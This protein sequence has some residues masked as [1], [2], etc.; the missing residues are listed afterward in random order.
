MLWAKLLFPKN[1]Y[2]AT[3]TLSI[4]QCNYMRKRVAQSNTRGAR[5]HPEERSL[6]KPR[7]RPQEKPTLLTGLTWTP[8]LQNYEK[9]NFCCLSHPACGIFYGSLRKLIQV[10]SWKPNLTNEK[11]I[12]KP[13]E[14]R[15]HFWWGSWFSN[16]DMYQNHLQNLAKSRY[17]GPMLFPQSLSHSILYFW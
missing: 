16:F 12:G 7:K 10:G 3:L 1:S 8:V 13:L 5:T 2:V 17:S 4:S 11:N 14:D 15:A 6:N 9:M